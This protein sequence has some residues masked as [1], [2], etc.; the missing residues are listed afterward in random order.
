MDSNT[1]NN[2]SVSNITTTKTSGTNNSSNIAVA[3]TTTSNNNIDWVTKLSSRKFWI[4]IIGFLTPLLVAFGVT[5]SK[6]AEVASIIMAGGTLI[7]YILCEGFVDSSRIKSNSSTTSTS[8]VMKIDSGSTASNS[9]QD[10]KV[11]TNDGET[12]I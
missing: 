10:S 4:A 3:T 5:D 9:V 11:I 12:S 7:A 8:T 2:T 1:T 6:I